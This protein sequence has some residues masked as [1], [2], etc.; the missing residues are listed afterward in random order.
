MSEGRKAQGALSAA[1]WPPLRAAAALPLAPVRL[2]ASWVSLWAGVIL[3]ALAWL[4]APPA[5]FVPQARMRELNAV[6]DTF[7]RR[8]ES[9]RQ[10]GWLRRRHCTVARPATA[11]HMLALLA[12]CHLALAPCR[13]C[14]VHRASCPHSALR[15]CI[16]PAHLP[17]CQLP[18]PAGAAGAAGGAGGQ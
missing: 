3:Q 15:H 10:V 4:G 18:L 13:P 11:Q 14:T 6:I 1:L 9:Y 5:G 12:C 2:L 16:A 17:L 7:S 8:E